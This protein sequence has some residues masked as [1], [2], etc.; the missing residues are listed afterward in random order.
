MRKP[1]IGVVLT[2]LPF[3]NSAGLVSYSS[4][5]LLAVIYTYRVHGVLPRFVIDRLRLRRIN[6]GS[7]AGFVATRDA[8]SASVISASS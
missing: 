6:N 8:T 3:A 7:I 1:Y 2:A 4:L 5:Q